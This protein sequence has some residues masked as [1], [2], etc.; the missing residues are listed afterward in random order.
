VTS[1]QSVSSDINYSALATRPTR[2]ELRAYKRWAR[3]S[4]FRFPNAVAPRI[5][6]A[7]S[8][9]VILLLGLIVLALAAAMVLFGL[10]IEGTDSFVVR[11]G[12]GILG[13]AIAAVGFFFL[14]R[15]AG[16]TAAKLRSPW[17][18]RWK[19][20]VFA[21]ENGFIFVP[22]S[23]TPP[24]GGSIIA[25]HPSSRSWDRLIARTGRAV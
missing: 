11:I 15:S 4:E 23:T 22:L 3:T 24:V 18:R 25:T 12:V 19:L 21:S 17:I 1:E 2:K 8:L 5:A 16:K 6:A 20:S 10:F 7:F 14:F 13:I 9:L